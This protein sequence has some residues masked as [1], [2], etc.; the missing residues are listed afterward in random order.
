MSGHKILVELDDQQYKIISDEA[1]KE[2]TSLSA[3]ASHIIKAVI[4]DLL[5]WQARLPNV[6]QSAQK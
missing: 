3:V 2:Q 4:D 1:H 5:Y 6:K